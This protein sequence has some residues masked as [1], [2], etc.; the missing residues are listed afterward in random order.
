[1]TTHISRTKIL[2]IGAVAALLVLSVGGALAERIEH[3]ST[4]DRLSFGET[5]GYQ[6]VDA[7]S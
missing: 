3:R 1:M 2:A 7:R 5:L 4:N 6:L